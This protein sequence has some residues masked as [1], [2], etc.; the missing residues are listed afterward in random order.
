MP[1]TPSTPKTKGPVLAAFAL[2][3]ACGC[4]QLVNPFQDDLPATSLVT[5]AS[6]A[7]VEQL[8][9]EQE[10]RARSWESRLLHPQDPGVAH[11]PLWWSDFMEDSGGQ[12]GRFAWTWEDYFALGY[13]PARFA[14]NTAAVP[15]SMIVDPPGSLRCSDGYPNPQ[16]LAY[17]AHDPVH[18]GGEAIL[19]D[20]VEVYSQPI[21][22]PE[23]ESEAPSALP[24]ES[25]AP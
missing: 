10:P 25:A 20:L 21:A 15:V 7:R 1:L 19:P 14:V 8:A 2:L 16:T 11:W 3:T 6:A 22:A 17:R 9:P 24:G 4:S 12:D 18:C 23:G 13:C 5:T